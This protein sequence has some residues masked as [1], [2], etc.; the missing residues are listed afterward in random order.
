MQVEYLLSYACAG[1]DLQICVL[2]RQGHQAIRLG[3]PH[4]INTLHGK[5][6]LIVVVVHLYAILKAQYQQLPTSLELPD[7]H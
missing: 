6:N 5:L 7:L 1:R 3:H 4:A 2:P